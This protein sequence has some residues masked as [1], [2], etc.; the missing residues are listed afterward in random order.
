MWKIDRANIKQ[1]YLYGNTTYTLEISLL[2]HG[3]R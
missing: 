1:L 3:V 2:H